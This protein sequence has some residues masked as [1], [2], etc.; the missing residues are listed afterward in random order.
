MNKTKY[1]IVWQQISPNSNIT[2]RFW[3]KDKKGFL[4]FFFFG[5][6][7]NRLENKDDVE[8]NESMLLKGILVGLG[9][10]K[11]PLVPR[12]NDDLLISLMPILREGFKVPSAEMMILDIAFNMKREIS[13]HCSYLALKG[14]LK[15]IS[16]SDMVRSDL[17]MNIW[18][19]WEED[20]ENGY[21]YM[22][23]AIDN[24]YKI[25][26]NNILPSAIEMIVYI[27]FIATYFKQPDKINEF[28]EKYVVNHIKKKV[29]KERIKFLFE[30][31]D[32]TLKDVFWEPIGK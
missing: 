19:L 29:L 31:K 2:K 28:F 4:P 13:T 25:D 18:E 22:D 17:L 23:E 10:K 3:V 20:S 24:F 32:S 26:L 21:S 8:L 12:E 16:N 7:L 27:T 9:Q 1:S 15:I 6:N 11:A 5:E 30:N 14:G